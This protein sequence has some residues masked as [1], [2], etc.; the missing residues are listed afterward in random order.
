MVSLSTLWFEAAAYVP[1]TRNH[2]KSE[3]L[4]KRFTT[5]GYEAVSGDVYG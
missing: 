2:N 4:E 5:S 3:N 1:K